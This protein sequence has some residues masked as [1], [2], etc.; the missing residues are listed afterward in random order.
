MLH[1]HNAPSYTGLEGL[2]R[3]HTIINSS[4]MTQT[5]S[6]CKIP[7]GHASTIKQFK[8]L[9]FYTLSELVETNIIVYITK[10]WAWTTVILKQSFLKLKIWSHMYFSN[11]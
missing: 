6:T 1:T 2:D 8:N 11:F 5:K 10:F 3:Y 9:C 4:Q 7:Q